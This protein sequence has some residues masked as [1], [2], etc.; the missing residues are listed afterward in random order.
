MKSFFRSILNQFRSLNKPARLFLLALF[1]DGLLFSGWNLFFNL[2][3]IDA[4]YS[5]EFLG[6][7]NAAPSLSALILGVPMGLLSDRMGRKRAMILGFA[8]ANF[9]IIGMILV[10]AEAWKLVLALIFGAVGQL[11]FLSQA[12]FMMRA[13][14]DRSRDILFSL[15]FGMFPLAST[16]G[17]FLAGYLPGAYTR[18]FGNGTAISAYQAVLLFCVCTSFLVLV[19]IFFIREPK[20]APVEKQV[21]PIEPKPSVWKTLSRP[22]TLK[23]ALPNLI[24]GLG[25]AT[26]VPYLNVFFSEHFQLSDSSLGLLFSIGSLA[27]GVGCIIGPRL[28]GR[29]G[30]KIRT[31]TLGQGISLLFLLMI[32]FSPWPWL[33]VIGFI[34]RGALMNMVS[35]LFDAFA[36]EQ[37]HE[38]EHGAVNSIR[39]LA[40]SVGW[41]VG[42]YISGVV[43]QR[44]GFTP[45]FIST[46]ILYA[47]GISLTW[48]FF[49]PRAEPG[50]VASTPVLEDVQ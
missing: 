11:Y 40:W 22:L 31:I 47:I 45:L 48:F 16:L 28:V 39:N 37:S 17:N 18:W 41:T 42:P 44:W 29:L 5:R 38:S 7:I 4:G 50:E 34:M 14:D 24:I 12:P 19:P 1:L 21:G 36:L 30:G 20:S 27:T 43:Q 33:A 23:L 3:I 35:P 49:H 46:G 15:S 8:L 2:Y 26:L 6:L 32:G 13:S 9:A 10:Q 25:A